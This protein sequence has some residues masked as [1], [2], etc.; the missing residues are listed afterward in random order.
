MFYLSIL[1]LIYIAYYL[2]MYLKKIKAY[3]NS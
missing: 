2:Y 1:K 3:N